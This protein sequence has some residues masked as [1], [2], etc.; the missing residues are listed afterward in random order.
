MR[1]FLIVQESICILRALP[2]TILAPD[3]W[4]LDSAVCKTAPPTRRFFTWKKTQL[5][6]NAYKVALTVEVDLA[7]KPLTYEP[8]GHHGSSTV[9]GSRN[10]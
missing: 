2:V 4:L 1:R 8:Q 6:V 7:L 3:S 5:F 10:V 9:N